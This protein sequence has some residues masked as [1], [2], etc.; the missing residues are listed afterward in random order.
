[1]NSKN[2]LIGC[3][4]VAACSLANTS[5]AQGNMI[6]SN[7]T[8][9]TF[10]IDVGAGD[11]DLCTNPCLVLGTSI[12]PGPTTILGCGNNLIAWYAARLHITGSSIPLALGT[13]CLTFPA[14]ANFS[15]CSNNYTVTFVNNNSIT[16]N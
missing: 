14:T 8:T 16:I 4:L 1:M 11:P 10:T 6:V 15:D 2:V 12:P 9:C 7:T 5:Q 3:L 13:Q